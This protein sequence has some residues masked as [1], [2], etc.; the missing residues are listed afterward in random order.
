MNAITIATGEMLGADGFIATSGMDSGQ[1]RLHERFGFAVFPET[2][3]YSARYDDRVCV[4]VR[5][6]RDRLGMHADLIGEIQ[7]VLCGTTFA[8]TI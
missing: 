1:H 6:A 8:V 5:K 7:G 4:I 2:Q 3:R